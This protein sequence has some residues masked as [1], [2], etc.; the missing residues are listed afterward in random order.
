MMVVSLLLVLNFSIWVSAS[1]NCDRQDANAYM[2]ISQRLSVKGG[3]L[4]GKVWDYVNQLIEA[5]H[6]KT[7]SNSDGAL[8]G[9]IGG[10][11]E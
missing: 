11:S 2:T 3:S 9:L 1:T 4:S 6:N 8:L 5:V 10:I 7:I